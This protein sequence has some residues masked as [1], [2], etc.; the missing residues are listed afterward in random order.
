M[1]VSC[2]MTLHLGRQLTSRDQATPVSSLVLRPA[3]LAKCF[4]SGLMTT[5]VRS[6]GTATRALFADLLSFNLLICLPFTTTDWLQLLLPLNLN[7]FRSQTKALSLLQ[8]LMELKQSVTT[9]RCLSS[10]RVTRQVLSQHV[11]PSTSSQSERYVS[12]SVS[13]SAVY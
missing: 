10:K 8:K 11:N 13:V 7:Q 3:R 4:P 12:Y 1:A 5:S 6:R 9:R 2:H